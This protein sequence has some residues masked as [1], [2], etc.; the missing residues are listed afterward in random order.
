[1]LERPG[2]VSNLAS[3]DT[4]NKIWQLVLVYSILKANG[5]FI[6]PWSFSLNSDGSDS[7]NNNVIFTFCKLFSSVPR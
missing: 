3:G 1:V 5:Y 2:K 4:K 6:G 7:L